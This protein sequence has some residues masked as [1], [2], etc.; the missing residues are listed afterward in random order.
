MSDL[1]ELSIFL[2]LEIRRNR[3]TGLLTLSQH[4]YIDRI[5]QRHGME[6]VRP[7]LTPLDPNTRLSATNEL[8]SISTTK[9]E[10]S[11]ELYQSAVGS[12]MYAM[13]GTRPDLAY[14]VGLVSQFNHSPRWEHWVAVKRIFRYLVGTKDYTL[15]YGT[16]NS[17]G[18]Y[19]DADWGSGHDRKSVG[20]F[21]FLLN[22]GAISWAS[23]KQSSMALSTTEA[24]YMG[25][26]Q[27]AKEI[28][29]LRVLLK[30]IGAF[31]HI[32]QMSVLNGDNQGAIALARNPEYHAR[33]KHIDI[34][35]HFIRDLVS[36]ETIHLQFCPSTDMIA[37]IMTKALTRVTHQK[38]LQAMGLT[39]GKRYGNPREG[40]C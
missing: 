36:T 10:V 24:E 40:A 23:K 21:V 8:D 33:T 30:E 26:T 19:S 7:S 22:G 13:L 35:Y 17:S 9:K 16:S 20:G 28:V 4:Q 6:D 38:H 15:Q 27:A 29:W 39:K 2:G 32:D 12:L 31:K 37:D 1:G 14:A 18:G 25:M 11:L 34:Q 3:S 5:L